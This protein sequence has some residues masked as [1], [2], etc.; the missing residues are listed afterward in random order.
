MEFA[1]KLLEVL[2]QLAILII[3]CVLSVKV[4]S[5]AYQV[6]IN[7]DKIERNQTLIKIMMD[8]HSQQMESHEQQIELLKKIIEER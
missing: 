3:I 8:E 1:R 6:D 2:G 7:Q 4:F 5:N